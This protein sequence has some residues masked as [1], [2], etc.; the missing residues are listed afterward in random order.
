VDAQNGN[1]SVVGTEW[2]TDRCEELR[3]LLS[4]TERADSAE[5]NVVEVS[6]EIET[7][8]VNHANLNQADTHNLN[9]DTNTD[10]NAQASAADSDDYAFAVEPLIDDST[11]DDSNT[12]VTTKLAS[13][14]KLAKAHAE[15]NAVKL[16]SN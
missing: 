5:V 16:E 6:T 11:T 10:A 15:R 9:H 12:S 8:D 13:L 1:P 14:V 7:S 2:W 4:W 3:Y